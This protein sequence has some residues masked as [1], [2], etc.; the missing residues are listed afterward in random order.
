[1]IC[2]I[3]SY[4]SSNG[5]FFCLFIRCVKW[6]MISLNCIG[7]YFLHLPPQGLNLGT[8]SC[9]DHA[10]AFTASLWQPCRGTLASRIFKRSKINV[11]SRKKIWIY[12]NNFV[13]VFSTV[14]LPALENRMYEWTVFPNALHG[15]SKL[16]RF[17]FLMI[18]V[19]TGTVCEQFTGWNYS[20]PSDRNYNQFS[21]KATMMD[22][23]LWIVYFEVLTAPLYIS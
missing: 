2:G 9:T 23:G 5:F 21:G 4:K 8:A 3:Y 20:L 14:S 22:Y 1:M 7:C 11:K 12:R 6:C 18:W 19:R 17:Q 10:S 13:R 16:F 15:K